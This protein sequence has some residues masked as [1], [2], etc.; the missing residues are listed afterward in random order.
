MKGNKLRSGTARVDARLLLA[1][2]NHISTHGG[3]GNQELQDVTGLSRAS[4]QRLVSNAN[5]QYGVNIIYNRKA[6]AESGE[7]AIEDWGV[8]DQTKVRNFVRTKP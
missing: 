1:M 6:F 2:L 3:V 4:V 8:F 7:Y 5:E